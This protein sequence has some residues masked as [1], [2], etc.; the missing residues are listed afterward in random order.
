MVIDAEQVD[1]IFK[2]DGE[3]E[4]EL[5][6]LTLINGVAPTD[7]I[8]YD[9]HETVF[10][11][12][13]GAISIATAYVRMNHM[14]FINNVAEEFGGAINVEAPNCIIANSLFISNYAGVFGG[15]VD[16]EDDNC[17]VINCTFINNEA[18]NGGAIGYIASAGTIIDSYFENNTAE[19]G[20][21]IFIENGDITDDGSNS[22]LIQ[23]N[24]FI[25]NEAIQQGGA[26]EVENQQMSENADW[27]L[28]DSNE[29]I[30]NYAY[31]GGAISAYYGDAG[32]TNN[33]FINNTAGYGGAIASI[34]TTDSVYIIIG[35]IY[36]KNNS[37]INCSA[38]ENG[39][40]I[41][42]MGYFGTTANI[43]FVGGRTVY[44][45]DGKAVILN[46]SVCDDVGN[47][48]SG[49]P[50][51]FTVDGKKTLNQ[52]TDL[53][54]GIGTVRF[55]P[56]ENGT[57]VISG[58]FK[59]KFNINRI[60][61]VTGEIV[62]DNAI[63]DYFGTVHLSQ[64]SGDDD[65]TG[66]EDSPV[67]TFNQAY[68]L[69]T[70]DGGSFDIVVHGGSYGIDG[71]TLYRSF[72]MTGIGNPIFDGKNQNTMFALYGAPDDEFHI[73]GI[74]FRNG[75]AN[76]SKYGGMEEGGAIFF[77]GGTLYLEND[78]FTSNSAKSYGGAVH[79]NKGM[80]AWGVFYRAF[81]YI[82]N[83]T[84]TNNLA[85][86]YGGAISLY[87]SDVFVTNCAFASNKAKNGGAISVLNGM[88]NLTVINSSFSDNFALNTGGA[89]DIGALNTYAIR[90]FAVVANSTFTSNT[91][92]YG[93]AIIAG[94]SNI[95]CCVF[96]ANA[97]TSQG[98]A[99]FNNET[100]LGEPITDQTTVEYCIFENNTAESGLDYWGTSTLLKG[101]FWGG[102][103]MSLNDLMAKRIFLVNA[104]GNISWANIEIDGPSEIE[105]GEHNYTV[106]FTS[107]DKSELG[108]YL[109]DYIS[110]IS[111][112]LGV[113]FLDTEKLHYRAGDC[114][115]T[116][117][118]VRQH[119]R[120]CDSY[121]YV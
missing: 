17:S 44:S 61:L 45:N 13:G 85:D 89:L 97:A 67:K 110:M 91:A 38:E 71:Y 114:V 2:I 29:F 113:Y 10:Y 72:N 118:Y 96:T 90:Y 55:V 63:A 56:R 27:T 83:C 68:V 73:T 111:C 49:S 87:D 65:N 43:T 58:I 103:F 75:V 82:D 104:A 64:E 48:I 105:I 74:T 93:G 116:E 32:I 40:A 25:N 84:F 3:Y 78:V 30:N 99:I 76:P 86:Y 77:K 15:A 59:Y 7:G 107:L 37:I 11:A 14:T 92:D 46:V 120:R 26:I 115:N 121:Q 42:N 19:N 16:F 6:N 8:T 1:R 109:P 79:I 24:V 60:N 47:P 62:V 70:R 57:F 9:I 28:I 52:A 41:Y 34:S 88:A 53:V 20:A 21:A 54:E 117:Y 102:N 100:F 12:G 51:D 98:G 69:A 101:N 80:D 94:D 4:V 50:I 112:L 119:F 36:L 18:G 5:S 95:S 106:R 39:N 35:G 33:V 66:A 31:N 108:G 23:N 22:H 81:A